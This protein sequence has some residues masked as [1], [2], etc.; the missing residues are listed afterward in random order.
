MEKNIERVMQME[1]KAHWQGYSFKGNASKVATEISNIGDDVTPQQIVDY[2]KDENTEL[3]KC[4][5]WDNNEAADKWRLHE[6]RQ[7][8]CCLR[9]VKEENETETPTPI[10]VFYKTDDD[11]GYKPT[12][13]IIKNTDEYEK[14]L[15]RVTNELKAV[16][17][18]HK[19]L[20]EFE[21]VWSAIDEL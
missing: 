8:V 7:I 21:E 10:R 14:L 11:S 19:N 2:A 13:I 15:N 6:A 3:H 9:I 20:I 18:K 4:F 1:I 5:T 12:Q 17:N 16:R